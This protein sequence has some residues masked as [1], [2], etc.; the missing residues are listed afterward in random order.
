MASC[1][2][3][4]FS[5]GMLLNPITIISRGMSLSAGEIDGAKCALPRRAGISSNVTSAPA[6]ERQTASAPVYP[7]P[8][9]AGTAHAQAAAT[10]SRTAMLRVASIIFQIHFFIICNPPFHCINYSIQCRFLQWVCFCF[11]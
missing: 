3:Q 6:C 1:Q 2:F 4:S 10:A 8:G 5:Y 7:V 9:F 11:Q